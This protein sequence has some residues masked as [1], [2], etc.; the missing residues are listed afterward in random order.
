MAKMRPKENKAMTKTKNNEPAEKLEKPT[1][2]RPY[3]LKNEGQARPSTK[4]VKTKSTETA[5]DSNQDG[6][7]KPKKPR[8]R[9][10]TKAKE[11]GP[12]RPVGRPRTKARDE[13]P[14]RPVGRPKSKGKARRGARLELDQDTERAIL[15]LEA[16]LL[17]EDRKP[18]L[19]TR[20]DETRRQ[21]LLKKATLTMKPF[22][23][24]SKSSLKRELAN[25][26]IRLALD[27]LAKGNA[28]AMIAPFVNYVITWPSYENRRN[29]L[30]QIEDETLDQETRESAEVLL[31][32]SEH[33]GMITGKALK[34]LAEVLEAL[35]NLKEGI[36]G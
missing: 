4:A 29:Y 12:K 16:H 36:K 6:A 21:V 26:L 32:V 35:N 17:D 28:G 14:K 7:K 3:D 5:G 19:D 23:T 30:K 24:L 13:G 31:A 10:R 27:T 15:A 20:E 1:E 9:P 11:E 34:D 8:G 33:D 25:G 22:K 2:A 18:K